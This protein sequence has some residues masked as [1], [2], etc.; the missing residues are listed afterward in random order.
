M[1]VNRMTRVL[2]VYAALATLA[3]RFSGA[4][5]GAVVVDRNLKP[6]TAGFFGAA[7][8]GESTYSYEMDPSAHQ[9]EGFEYHTTNPG[10]QLGTPKTAEFFHETASGGDKQAW[11]THPGVPSGNDW[12]LSGDGRW[13]QDYK[14]SPYQGRHEAGGK[15]ASWFDSSVRQ[16]DAFGRIKAPYPGSPQRLVSWEERSINTT[17]KCAAAG[18]SATS[19]LFAYDP[20]TEVASNCKLNLGVHPTDFDDHYSGERLIEI[21]ING[22]TVNTDCFPLVSGC[23][24][25]TQ[26]TTFPCVKELPVDHLMDGAG[27]LDL[28]A[29]ISDMVDECPYEGNLLSAVPVVTCMVTPKEELIEE[30]IAV[31]PV[32]PTLPHIVPPQFIYAKKEL[33]CPERG[34]IALTDFTVNTTELP[35]DRCS[36]NVRLYQTDFD[37][38]QGTVEELEYV[39]VNGESVLSNAKPGLN[40]CK[41]AWAGAPLTLGEKEYSALSNHE[42]NATSGRITVTA[43]ISPHVD[44]CAHEG[45]LLNGFVEANCSLTWPELPAAFLQK[46][47]GHVVDATEASRARPVGLALRRRANE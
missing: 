28:S 23:N 13:I 5:A 19:S 4:V 46:G 38:E 25:T 10:R 41:K 33:R 12:R 6:L 8:E 11:Q 40:P 37:G 17:L 45:Y 21:K 20:N 1:A 42:L 43:K 30:K 35:I 29:Q 34:C 39:M 9:T 15:A 16:Y 24:M 2:N 7:S 44:E 3:P 18:C 22:N 14:S 36:I 31:A 32:E 26:M 27:I 47:L